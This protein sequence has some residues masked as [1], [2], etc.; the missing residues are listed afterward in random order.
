VIDALGA[1][2]AELDASGTPGGP[3]MI[4]VDDAERLDAMGR[5]LLDDLP[6]IFEGRPLAIV[7]SERTSSPL[8]SEAPTSAADEAM[9]NDTVHIDA[10]RARI[11]LGPLSSPVVRC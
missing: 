7:T 9:Q 8:V 5:A 3:A 10:R 11:V 2:L 4:F 1:R 6:F